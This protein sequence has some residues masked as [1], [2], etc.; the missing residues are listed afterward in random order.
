MD[1]IS[2]IIGLIVGIILGIVIVNFIILYR[3]RKML[4]Q[5]GSLEK[6]MEEALK[7]LQK[8]R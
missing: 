4:K 5:T 2:F 1:W 3:V 8:K 6:L 7:M